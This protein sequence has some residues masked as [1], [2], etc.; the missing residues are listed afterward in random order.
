M[1]KDKS[2]RNSIN[3]MLKNWKNIGLIILFDV[4][5]VML[6]VNIRFV[7]GKINDWFFIS[8]EGLIGIVRSISVL[9]VILV[10]IALLIAILSFFKYLIL[11]NL[12]EIFKNKEL[13]FNRFFSFLKLNLI[14]DIPIVLIYFICY[15]LIIAYIDITFAGGVNDIFKFLFNL[16][17]ILI[18]LLI[19]LIYTYTIS[20]SSHTFFLKEHSLKKILKQ[21]F[22]NSF[23][24]NSYRIYLDNLKIIFVSGAGLYLIYLL[25]DKLILSN[26]QVYLKYGDIHKPI[27]TSLS[28][29]ILYFLVLFNRINFYKNIIKNS[30]E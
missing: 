8:S 26:F 4:L 7:Y 22:V 2:I 12:R 21:T 28:V 6:V 5:F 15:V 3:I 10:E 24:L 20:N 1:K 29:L 23:K 17:L 9:I 13:E 11:I 30:S 27:I 18:G 14:I 19:I 25:I 16:I